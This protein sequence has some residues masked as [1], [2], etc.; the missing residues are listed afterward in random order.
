MSR[1]SLKGWIISAVLGVSVIGAI[2]FA[3]R[4]QA[5]QDERKAAAL[6]QASAAKVAEMRD[7]KRADLEAN[8]PQIVAAALATVE[9]DPASGLKSLAQYEAGKFPDVAAAV[10]TLKAAEDKKQR[11]AWQANVAAAKKAAAAELEQRKR[12][13]VQIGMTAERVL[14]SSWGKPERVNRTTS[15]R[16]TREQWVY[17]GHN[18]FLYFED[19]ILVTIQN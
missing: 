10:A 13:G 12:E 19:G 17:R 11:E 4:W 8:R 9:T 16:G 15:P 3:V 2:G 7:K 14:Q 5:G 1:E 6:Q 18:N